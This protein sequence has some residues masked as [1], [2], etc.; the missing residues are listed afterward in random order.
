MESS[1]KE[2]LRRSVESPEK[3]NVLNILLSSIFHQNFRSDY[4][5]EI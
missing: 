1:W 4:K 5:W 2:V 3:K